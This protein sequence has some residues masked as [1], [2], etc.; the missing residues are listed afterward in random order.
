MTRPSTAPKLL[1]RRRAAALLVVALAG[2]SC[3]AVVA[4][5]QSAVRR[6]DDVDRRLQRT[7]ERLRRTRDRET[8]LTREVAGYRTRIDALRTRLTPLEGRLGSLEDEVA[9][10]TARRTALDAR[11]R[12]ER[13]RL[14]R[15][16]DELASRRRALA[17]RLRV[18]YGQGEPDPVLVLLEAGSIGDAVEAQ[19]LLER[20]TDRDGELVTLTRRRA[21]EVRDARD[22]IEAAR[23]EVRRAEDRTR[24]LAD[25]V[26]AVTEE[27]RARRADLDRARAARQRLLSTVRGDREDIEAEA[28]G[29]RRRSAA[30]AA[31]IVSAQIPSSVPASVSRTPSARG[32][33]WPVNGA[34]TSPFGTRWGRMH[35]GIDIAVPTGTPVAAAASGRV[36]QAGWAGGYG[37]MVVIDHG[38]GIA[39]AYAHNSRAVVSAGQTVAQGQTIALAG[40]TGNSTGPHVH[41]EVRVGGG[42]VNPMGYL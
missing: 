18:I 13:A 8:V 42:P 36:I 30:L 33:V 2:S 25:E 12:S 39:T 26:R 27:L 19:R 3:A 15:A 31:R 40:S 41:F 14:A 35:E 29:L 23:D 28:A 10:L 32:M 24:A 4:L 1:P 5:G 17:D 22:R 38:G 11:L 20:I 7:E 37:V 6:K 21:D 34:L 9:R 16:E